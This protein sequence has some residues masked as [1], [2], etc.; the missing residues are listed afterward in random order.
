M[1]LSNLRKKTTGSFYTPDYIVD[2][3][4][5]RVFFYLEDQKKL[6]LKS[7]LEFKSSLEKITFFDPAVGT[8]NF[9][10]GTL[11]YILFLL[12][13]FNN[14]STK[15]KRNLVR[16]FLTKNFFGVEIDESVAEL[17]K[18]KIQSSFPFLSSSDFSN[19]KQGNSLVDDDAFSLFS[20]ETARKL[21]PFSWEENFSQTCFDVIIGNPPYYNLKKMKLIEEKSKLLFQYLKKSEKW[22]KLFRSSSDIYYYFLFL[23]VQKTKANG[24]LSF[25]IPNYWIYNTYSDILKETL[26]KYQILEILNF[27]EV[28]FFPGVNLSSCILTLHKKPPKRPTKV[29]NDI[30]PTHLGS[31]KQLERVLETQV[32]EIPPKQIKGKNWN[33]SRFAKIIEEL[34]KNRAFIPLNSLVT[35]FQGVSPG[36]KQVFVVTEKK[37]EELDL[38]REALVPFVSNKQIKRWVLDEK[39]K[40]YA[41]LPSRIKN[42]RTYPKIESYLYEKKALLIQGQDRLKLLLKNKIRWFDFSVYRNLNFFEHTK[43]KILCPYRSLSCSFSFDAE[44]HFGATD[45]YGI[46]SDNRENLLYLLAILNSTSFEF[47]YRE[48]GKRKGKMLEFFSK[49]LGTVLIP[50]VEEKKSLIVKVEKILSLLKKGQSLDTL[51]KIQDREKEINSEVAEIYGLDQNFLEKYFEKINP[52]KNR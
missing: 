41:I 47:W 27:G 26:S 29:L 25:I 36:V 37:A 19:I 11:K 45:V 30:L 6:L 38:E 1:N 12:R 13:Q 5:S 44:K 8:G 28:K 22:T 35:V 9:L 16:E 15:D 21:S 51:N 43:E 2:F 52:K 49:P 4:V 50:V 7:F 40:H 14:V 46:A 42:L 32:Y 39:E 10:L 31:K 20:L 3:M 33:L 34:Q 17:L 24:I 48:T 23:G 18:I